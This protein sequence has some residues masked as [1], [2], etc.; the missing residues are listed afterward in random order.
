MDGAFM[1]IAECKISVL[2]W[3]MI[4]SDCT[5]DVAHVWKGRFFRLDKHLDRFLR[6]VEKLRMQL[7]FD[8]AKL[9]DVLSE[10]VRRTG[11]DDVYVSMTCTRGRPPAGVRDPRQAKNTFYCFAIPFVW[12]ATLPQQEAGLH[13]HVS[14]IPRIAPE[15]VDPTVKNYHWLDMEMSLFEAYENDANFVVLTDGAGNITEGPGYNIFT[16]NNGRWATPDRGVLEGISR[17]TVLDLCRELNVSA[18]AGQLTETALRNAE[19]ILL[20]STAGGVMPVTKLDGKPVG[21]GT[22]GPATTRLRQLY[23][24]KHGDPGWSSPVKAA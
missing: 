19:E 8:R 15:S 22:P 11:L 6:G 7:P 16:Y 10:C 21:N 12:L 23:W 2:D 14:S 18:Q 13:L 4:R 1:P 24:Q 20:T 9:E 17:Q 5:Y 3:G